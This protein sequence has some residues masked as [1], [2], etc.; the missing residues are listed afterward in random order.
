M[1]SALLLMVGGWIFV[2]IW[3]PLVVFSQRK[4]HPKALFTLFFAELW[5]RF[6]FYGMRALLTLYMTKVLFF[7]MG[8]EL[9][10]SRSLGI[11]G[12]YGALV[13]AAPVIGGLLADKFLGFRRAILMGGILMALGHFVLAFE[14]S[15]IL[16]FL[17]LSLIV[18]GNGFFKPNISSFLGTFY[19]PNDAR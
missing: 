5:E 10:D 1:D 3:I 13:Y 4:V 2:A 7:D 11:Y 18:V 15:L 12:A 8:Q 17:A 6:S 9:A 19:E 14:G 16:F